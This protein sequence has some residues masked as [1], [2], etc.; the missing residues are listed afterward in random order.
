MEM[1][2][3]WYQRRTLIGVIQGGGRVVRS[4]TDTGNV[5][6]LDGSFGYLKSQTEHMI[7]D[8]WKKAYNIV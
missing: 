3:A 1:S 6:I 5:Y 7:P 4:E 8:W 2:T